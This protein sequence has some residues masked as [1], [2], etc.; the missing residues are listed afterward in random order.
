MAERST[1]PPPANGAP[2]KRYKEDFFIYTLEFLALA[3]GAQDEDAIQIEALSAFKWLKAAAFVD[4]A[5]DP[6]QE[7]T[8]LVPFVTINIRDGGSGRILFQNPVMLE[9]TFGTGQL[10]FILPVP[11]IFMQRSSVIVSV[12]NIS[13]NTYNLRLAFIGMKVFPYGE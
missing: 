11:R 4:I 2:K 1:L 10:P 6:L 7:D 5:G 8:Q 9:T 3:A 13:T 12:D